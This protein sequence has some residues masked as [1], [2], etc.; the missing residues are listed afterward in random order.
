MHASVRN[1]FITFSE[2]I[3]GR[4]HYMYLDV[5]GLVTIG[6]GNLIDVEKG[7]VGK[8][9]AEVK[10]LPFV[11][12]KGH[13]HAGKAA[14]KSDIEAEWRNVKQQQERAKGGRTAFM[15]ITE[16]RLNDDAINSL[17]LSKLDA[18]E[19]E[20]ICTPIYRDYWQWPADAQL[21][22]LSMAWALGTPALRKYWP[23]FCTACQQQDFDSAAMQCSIKTVN[24][25][26]VV[27][28]NAHNQLLFRNAAAVLANN[29]NNMAHNKIMRL[30]LHYPS[31]LRKPQAIKGRRMA[32]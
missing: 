1:Y 18:M 31:I 19:K 20:L 14:S 15:E 28:R 30:T 21:G 5:K 12:K 9:L 17:V 3:E 7:P 6:I 24:N 26:G 4:V 16:L 22:L 10:N 25:P 27:P 11:F 23:L 32:V 8:V 29:G 13:I 2:S